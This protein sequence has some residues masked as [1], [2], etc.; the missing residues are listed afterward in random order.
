MLFLAVKLLMTGISTGQ[1]SLHPDTAQLLFR[2][3]KKMTA[4]HFGMWERDIYGPVLLVDPRTRQV[5]ANEGD[6]AG[7]LKYEQGIYKGS[8]PPGVNVSNTSVHWSGRHWA[9]VMLPLPSQPNA[10]LNLLA[11]ELFHR[12]Q[13]SLGFKSFNP[14]NNHLDRKEGRIYLLLELQALA[15]AITAP[16]REEMQ[17]HL[18]AA[19]LFRKYRYTLFPLSDSTENLMELNEGICEYSGQVMSGRNDEQTR[20]N[21]LA[22][23]ARFSGTRSFLRSFAYECVPVYGWLLEK[24]RKN[25]QKEVSTGT[26]LTDFFIKSFG[27]NMPTDIPAAARDALDGYN[28]TMIIEAETRREEQIAMQIAAYRQKFVDSPHLVLPLENMRMAFDYM[29]I[30]PIEGHG[31]VYPTI[32][33]TDNWGILDVKS[34]AMISAD[35]K[36]IHVGWPDKIEANMVSGDGWTLTLNPG[37][38]VALNSDG[39]YVLMANSR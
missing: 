17:K 37:Y 26:N 2:D 14:D 29:T 12:A 24:T 1:E 18:T 32:R 20:A 5:I 35:W 23:I 13:P 7:Y 16:V 9:M 28:G 34:G 31:T 22:R 21:L 15:A 3:L 27:I 11:H 33:V 39:R 19:L 8:L 30:Q 36:R 4:L 25:W 10:R 38:R 6:T